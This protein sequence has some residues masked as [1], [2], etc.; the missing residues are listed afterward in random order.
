[1]LIQPLLAFAQP[2]STPDSAIREIQFPLTENDTKTV[3]YY[4]NNE[5]IPG[6]NPEMV[7]TDSITKIEIKNDEY[8]NRA[9]FLTVSP[10][11]VAEL[12][13]KV[14]N[15]F[16]NLDP[17]CEFPGGNG[18]LKEWLDANIKV[19]DGYKGRERVI[20][21]FIVHPDGTIS[22]PKIMRPSKNEA[23]NEEALRLVNALPKFRVKYSTPQ[24]GNLNYFISITFTAPGT[25]F[26]RGAETSFIDQFPA[27][28]KNIRKFYDNEVFHTRKDSDYEIS[29]ICTPDFI[30]QL[31]NANT[32]N[33]P[34]Y[35]TWLLRSGMQDGDDTP[36]TVQSIIP[37]QNNTAIV[38]WS[39]MGHKGATTLTL[40]ESDGKWKID[41][42]TV[43]AGFN[44]L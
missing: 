1:M 20:V 35:A 5:W 30:Q 28:E 4:F 17:R 29:D 3:F 18:K 27:I 12:K 40:T 34:G 43:P 24:Q 37:G 25:I 11:T 10:E 13:A 14:N 41:Y 36:S 44:P 31:T 38:H 19:P 6:A 23:A 42:S 8:N 21:S 32:Y 26:I 2:H 22:N 15:L 39:D 7:N 9:V 33:S 16:I